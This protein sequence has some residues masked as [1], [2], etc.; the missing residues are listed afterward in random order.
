MTVLQ[1]NSGFVLVTPSRQPQ[2]VSSLRLSFG[3]QD[4]SLGRREFHPVSSKTSR[5]RNPA[6]LPPQR[7]CPDP[8]HLAQSWWQLCYGTSQF[9]F[10]LETHTMVSHWRSRVANC[11][12]CRRTL[13]YYSSDCRA[14]RP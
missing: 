4:C 13:L 7:D 9:L 11:N 2:K 1:W 8:Q 14:R 5:C 6:C 10:D 3:Q 12:V